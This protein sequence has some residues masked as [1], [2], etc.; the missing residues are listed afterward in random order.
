MVALDSSCQDRSS[1]TS[2]RLWVSSKRITK[3]AT[4]CSLLEF[5]PFGF[6]RSGSSLGKCWFLPC[7]L[8]RAKFHVRKVSDLVARD[9]YCGN[10]S[11]ELR[12]SGNTVLL[13]SCWV[14]VSLYEPSG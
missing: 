12:T 4:L 11:S 1:Y 14:V 10:C 5:R 2:R 7:A 6:C 8:F 3:E 9:R 13:I